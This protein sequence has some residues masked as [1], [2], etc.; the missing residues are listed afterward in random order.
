MTKTLRDEF[1]MAALAGMFVPVPLVSTHARDMAAG[2][3]AIADSMM[4]ERL[5][6]QA[7]K[8]T[9][10]GWIPWMGG[11]PPPDEAVS[12]RFHNDET[13]VGLTSDYDWE[14]VSRDDWR[15]KEYKPWVSP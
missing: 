6:E 4:A 2:A 5:K 11:D 12:V 14:I 15:I 9:E 3:Y 7:E 10:D 1:A 8:P 13:D